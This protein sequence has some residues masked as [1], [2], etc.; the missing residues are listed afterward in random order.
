MTAIGSGMTWLVLFASYGLAFW[1]GIKLIM[2][3]RE[4]CFEDIEK[5]FENNEEIP[6][7]SLECD[8]EYDAAKMII[9]SLHATTLTCNLHLVRFCFIRRSSFLS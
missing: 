7:G 8:V 4:E 3:D 5:L 6:S 9:V 1:Y 2:D